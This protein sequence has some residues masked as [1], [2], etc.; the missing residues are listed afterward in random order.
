MV[1][2]RITAYHRTAGENVDAIL[3]DGFR[4]ATGTYMTAI[5]HTGVWV[6]ME[7]PWD[8][9]TGGTAGDDELLAIDIPYALFARYEWVEEGK[10]YREAL[11]PAAEL[12]HHEVWRAWECAECEH[13]ARAGTP[14]GRNT[15][16]AT[17]S[18]ARLRAT[19]PARTA[20]GVSASLANRP[21]TPL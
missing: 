5:R 14:G 13:I 10:P 8:M 9:A 2:E 12:S 17:R 16:C 4:D 6:T 21:E 20:A 1:D 7:R 11:I 3:R 18:R 19:P 15:K